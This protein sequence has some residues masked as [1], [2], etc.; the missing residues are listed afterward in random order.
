MS[1]PR[2]CP[3][4]GVALPAGAPRFCI[5][6]R[7]EL[8]QPV[9][10]VRAPDAA[11]G[12]M[13][14]A[15]PAGFAATGATVR[16]SNA[17]VVQT[18]VG[19]TIK[20]PTDG[21][22]P[23]GMW[24]AA[25][26]PG[27]DDTIALYAPLRAVVGGWSGTTTDGWRKIGPIPADDG[28]GM[29]LIRFDAWRIWFPARGAG[30]GLRLHARIVAAS[31]ADHGRTRRGFTYRVNGD[32]P[33][34]VYESWW[35]DAENRRIERPLPFI[36]LMA[37]PRVPRISDLAEQIGMLSLREAERLVRGSA[38][39]GVFTLPDPAQQRTPLGRGIILHSVPGGVF[40]A[41]FTSLAGRPQYR[42]KIDR[43]FSSDLRTWPQQRQVIVKEAHDL[44]LDFDT[45]PVVE[46]WL[47]RNG[48]DGALLDVPFAE[49][50]TN[51]IAIAFRRNQIVRVQI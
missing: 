6:C 35:T 3:Q 44:G 29:L 21:A 8:L 34:R 7:H 9:A 12:A 32:P 16:L 49:Y 28:S 33:M 13:L 40:G 31:H 15:A 4:C 45:D 11:T 48:H 51:R 14:P 39:P 43:P 1:L 25:E 26:P 24:F 41:A 46:W 22:I 30:E 42:V 37:P 18:V 20:L 2:F 10:A 27:P 36:Q 17:G 5:A 19:G 23:P 50:G 47:D 38:A